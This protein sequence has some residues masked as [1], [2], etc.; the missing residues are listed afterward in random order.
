MLIQQALEPLSSLLRLFLSFDYEY[1]GYRQS[2]TYCVGA[3]TLSLYRSIHTP[4]QHLPSRHITY[5]LY[6][7]SH[8]GKS[9][10][11]NIHTDS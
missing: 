7:S 3:K 11:L 5:C 6:Q 4:K 2:H 1:C 10:R 9:T 8:S